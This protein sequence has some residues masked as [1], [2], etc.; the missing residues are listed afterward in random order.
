MFEFVC[1]WHLFKWPFHEQKVYTNCAKFG[2]CFRLSIRTSFQKLFIKFTE[3][4][5]LILE[6]CSFIVLLI[7]YSVLRFSIILI[8]SFSGFQRLHNRPLLS[9]FKN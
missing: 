5:F 1:F 6:L 3:F 8:A 9:I 2:I 4:P 7:S